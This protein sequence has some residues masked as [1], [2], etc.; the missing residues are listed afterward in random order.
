MSKT[1]ASDLTKASSPK[2]T[3]E[4]SESDLSKVSGGATLFLKLDGVKGESLDDKHKD[5]IDV[6]S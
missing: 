4:L 2:N 6:G 1:T 3:P 5:T